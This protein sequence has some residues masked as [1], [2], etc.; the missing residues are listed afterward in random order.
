MSILLQKTIQC[1]FSWALP[2]FVGGGHL[3][4]K[5]LMKVSVARGYIFVW[6]FSIV[7]LFD[8]LVIAC[9]TLSC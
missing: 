7:I 1:E 9:V 8:S 2:F 3:H 5:K 6:Q 4:T